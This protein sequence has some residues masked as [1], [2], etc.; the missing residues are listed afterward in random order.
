MYN[1]RE[2]NEDERLKSL[3]KRMTQKQPWH[4]P[5]HWKYEGLVQFI[6]TSACYEH[7]PIIGLNPERMQTFENELLNTCRDF[8]VTVHAWCI[9]PNHYHLLLETDKI[10]ELQ[11]VGLG[12]LHGRT[13]FLWNGEENQRGRKIWY[14]SFE[15]PMKSHRHYWASL[16]YIHNNPVHHG[17]VKKWQNWEFSSANN[18]LENV[19]REKASDIWK[20]FPILD[21]GK[22]WD[23]FFE[24]R[25]RVNA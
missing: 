19:G 16:N 2:M 24:K 25:T 23:E 17:Y 22:D 15:R 1:W 20:Q 18:F 6:V 21:Y 8:G 13:S 3:R 10:A 11:S 12:R 9:L 7:L 14:K 5:P 4:A